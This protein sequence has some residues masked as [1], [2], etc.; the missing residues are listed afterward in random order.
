MVIKDLGD[1]SAIRS[2]AKCAARIGQAF[3]QTFSSV[4]LSRSAIREI[5][6]VKRNNRVF[7]DGVG[8]KGM[9]SLDSRL[10]GEALCLRRSMIKFEAPN[11]IDIEICGA[12]FKPLPLYLN[13]PLIK[14]LEDLGVPDWSFVYLQAEA[15]EQLRITTLNPVNAANFLQRNLIGKAARLSWLI[16]KLSYIGMSFQDDHF[17]RSVLE[18]AV[19][20]QLK[21]LKYRSRIYVE[22]GMTVYGIMDE[23]DFLEEG[24]IYCSVQN[25]KSGMVL[26]GRVVITRN[27]ALHPGDV[28]CVDAVDAPKGSPLRDVHNCVVFSSKGKR[29]LPSQ[30]SGG[31][32]D[33]DLYNIIYDNDLFPQ[34]TCEPADYAI[35][36]P[37]D[38][39]REVTRSD[40][41]AFFILFMENDQLG[42]I[43]TLHQTLADQKA[44]GTFDPQ[45]ILLAQLASTA[46][47]FSKTGIPA[48]LSMMQKYSRVR[49]DFQATGP[50][51]LVEHLISLEK[52]EA[53]GELNDGTDN[54]DEEEIQQTTRY[55]TSRKVLGK[56]Y[57]AIDEHEFL[58]DIQR[59][60]KL[61]SGGIHNLADQVWR[62]VQ[63]ETALVQYRHWLQFAKEVKEAYED[64]M[65]DTMLQFSAHPSHFVS[66]VEVFCGSII[67]KNGSQSKRQREFS[68]S[69]KE[70][71]DRDVSYTIMS[72]LRGEEN[73]EDMNEEA[74]ARSIAC[75]DVARNYASVRK[76]VGKLVSF[77]WV[78]A[79]V[80][81][82]EVEK[83]VGA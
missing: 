15:V 76:K 47:D 25:D 62:Y 65:T 22:N 26:T 70:K 75:L 23:T 29:D 41:T 66:E 54:E 82:R 55:Y 4:A 33:G 11:S 79:A 45:C 61:N 19:L 81:L 27:P 63:K 9:I 24:Q 59:Q 64:S 13:R 34:R 73:D 2:P 18:L 44:D 80:C 50:R 53:A 57:R 78:A 72:I 36:P 21:E 3:S 16:R 20:I 56:L 1:F 69:M 58:K 12:G 46:V 48:D 38:I 39:G 68:V 43:S 37:L 51:V 8:A 14:I 7:S 49:P 67:G 5:P 10:H 52:Q 74:L 32:L 35:A 60:S 83:F 28:Q 31:D 17:L 6:D 42:R 77:T 30:L 40:M 71:H